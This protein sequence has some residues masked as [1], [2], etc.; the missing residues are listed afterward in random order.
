[1]RE[2]LIKFF[3]GGLD[4]LVVIVST[5]VPV[6]NIEWSLRPSH[7]SAACPQHGERFVALPD[8][9]LERTMTS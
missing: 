1:L 4:D 3:F 5:I 9:R 6:T 8:N 2:K 7:V